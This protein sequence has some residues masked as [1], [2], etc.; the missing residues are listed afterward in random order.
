MSEP[1]HADGAVLAGIRDEFSRLGTEL[2]DAVGPVT[3]QA[4]GVT[5]GA[6]QFA[7]SLADGATAFQLS[8]SQAFA[9][10]GR[11]AGNIGAN[12]GQLGIDLQR[13]DLD[14]S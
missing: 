13:L 1:I 11:T 8:W 2:L 5:A 3:G 12:V 10:T 9:V 14:A 7:G 4:E 6:G